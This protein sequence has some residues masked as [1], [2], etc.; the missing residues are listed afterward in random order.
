MM[1]TQDRPSRDLLRRRPYGSNEND[2]IGHAYFHV[3]QVYNWLHPN[4]RISLKKK[5]LKYFFPV[6]NFPFTPDH[7][8]VIERGGVFND[9]TW[10]HPETAKQKLE[11]LRSAHPDD[12]VLLTVYCDPTTKICDAQLGISGAVET[13]DIKNGRTW[14]EILSRAAEREFCEETGQRR[15]LIIDSRNFQ[16]VWDYNKLNVIMPCYSYPERIVSNGS[17]SHSSDQSKP[18]VKRPR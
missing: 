1:I 12:Y 10:G 8:F 13:C 9:G 3:N 16:L 15:I 5:D 2:I 11:I 14:E 17:S 6:E 18:V 4:S 7:N